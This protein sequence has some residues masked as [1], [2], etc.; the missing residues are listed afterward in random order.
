MNDLPLSFIPLAAAIL[1]APLSVGIIRSTKAFF[2]GRKGFP[3]F[4]TYR[5]LF[6]LM[7]KGI[8]YS[9]SV[10]WLFKIAPLSSLAASIIACA[11]LPFGGF[12]GLFSFTGGFLLIAYLFG[13]SRFVT[14]LASLDTASAFEGM[15]ANREA[16][17][18]VFAEPALLLGFGAVVVAPGSSSLENAISVAQNTAFSDYVAAAA[19]AAA[20]FFILALAE[21]SRIPVDDPTTHLE[22]TMIHEA[23]ILDNSGPDLAFIEYASSL[24][25]W[26]F[27][28]LIADI[29]LPF[30][31]VGI[32]AQF[33]GTF[34]IVLA[35]A[36]LTGIVE[37]SMARLRLLKV[38]QFIGSAAAF[39]FIAILFK[40]I[41]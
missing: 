37:S 14:M 40:A 41:L 18:S 17:F 26:F 36:A 15:G 38:P 4:Q 33:F 8:V 25:V 6:K 19:L 16:L 10:S 34:L 21:N 32:I 20:A 39:A 28:V 5:D 31:H 22:L 35:L 12:S 30:F 2:A 3:V 13:A 23:M 24:K 9:S 11:W 1:F 7:H 27:D 29:V